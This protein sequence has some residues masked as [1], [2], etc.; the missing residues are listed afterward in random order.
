MIFQHLQKF[1]KLDFIKNK[2]QIFR[3][4]SIVF[5]LLGFFAL[6]QKNNDYQV[7]TDKK[8]SIIEGYL[9]HF[10]YYKDTVQTRKYLDSAAIVTKTMREDSTKMFYDLIICYNRADLERRKNNNESAG[11]LFKKYLEG[12]NAKPDA[13]LQA[14]TYETYLWL[15]GLAKLKGQFAEAIEFYTGAIPYGE[16]EIYAKSSTYKLIGD[17]YLV[18][19][20]YDVAV[21]YYK[22]SIAGFKQLCQSED[23]K[24]RILPRLSR[25]YEAM[26]EYH[27]RQN[28]LDS[29]TFYL[30]LRRRLLK[31]ALPVAL[32]DTYRLDGMLANEYHKYEEAE[33]CYEKALV[34]AKA[35][36]R[37]QSVAEIFQRKGEI[38]LKQEK[39]VAAISNFDSAMVWLSQK[40]KIIFKYDYAAALA[41]KAKAILQ[42]DGSK[43]QYETIYNLLNNS[44]ILL[45]DVSTDY[46]NERDKQAQ[47]ALQHEV[48][49]NAIATAFELF[50]QNKNQSYIQQALIWSDKSRSVALRHA[51]QLRSITN[52]AGVPDSIVQKENSLHQTI[53]SLENL[54][55]LSNSDNEINQIAQELQKGRLNQYKL[56]QYITQKFPNYAQ[57][58]FQNNVLDINKLVEKLPNNRTLIEY[59]IA[60]D[61]IYIFVIEKNKNTT[62]H[63]ILISEGKLNDLVFDALAFIK[64]E[65]NNIPIF[66]KNANI[67]YQTLIE[68]LSLKREQQL[69]IVPDGVLALLPFETLLTDSI[70]TNSLKLPYLLQQHSISYHYALSL[71]SLHFLTESVAG[72]GLFIPNFKEDPLFYQQQQVDFM[73]KNIENITVFKGNE[74]TKQ[75]FME[76]AQQFQTLHLST[77]GVANDSIGDLSYLRL[78]NEERLYASELYG[79]KL[80]ASLIVLSA[81]ETANGELRSGEGTVGL[82]LG[83][84]YSGAKSIVSSLWNVNQNSTNQFMMLW[85]QQLKSA[86]NNSDALQKAKLD[87]MKQNPAFAHPKYWSAFVLIGNPD[88]KISFEKRFWK[89]PSFL[90]SIFFILFIF[91]KYCKS[92]IYKL[93]NKNL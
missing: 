70:A 65:D 14:F 80:N 91:V 69:L 18:Q 61:A 16:S 23:D 6:S 25:C 45:D 83:F 77:H 38:M 68:P 86:Q 32:I 37:N 8:I 12:V 41:Q 59:F 64:G 92:V 74:A 85:Y 46:S 28:H 3:L 33:L 84:L 82:T 31:F 55:R 36:F 22:K 34:L 76:K 26:A 7:N 44:I 11:L 42:A 30:N 20:Q 81:C 49:E 51:I 66:Q 27:R 40:G 15:G 9:E 72:M 62:M 2:N 57:L 10:S 63:K 87:L 89:K 90:V 56:T 19:N 21:N 4:S 88:E 75:Q 73:T 43:K 24:K 78:S 54:M 52:F 48:F 13:N 60:P 47:L 17:I 53:A 5:L 71:L 50:Q 58:K 35:N 93:K 39:Y 67:L 79:L 1:N 29:A